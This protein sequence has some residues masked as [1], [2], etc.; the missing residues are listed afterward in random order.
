L[1][2]KLAGKRDAFFAY[3]ALLL[4]SNMYM[5]KYHLGAHPNRRR[6][7]IEIGRFFKLNIP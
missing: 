5:P 6:K 2:L 1:Y 7:R 3:S 4:E